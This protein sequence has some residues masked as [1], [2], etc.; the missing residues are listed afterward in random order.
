M[1]AFFRQFQ[2]GDVFP[3]TRDFTR[4]TFRI[5]VPIIVS[6]FFAALLHVIDNY[7]IGQLGVLELAAVTQ[8]NRITFLFQLVIFGLSGGT[9]AYVSQY[10]GK[11]DMKGIHSVMGLA[12][13]LSTLS[14]L[15]FILPCVLMP[16]QL[17]SLLLKDQ[18]SVNAAAEYLSIIVLGY[19][20]A[21]ITQCYGTVQKSTEQ[22]RLS[23]FASITALAMN[24]FLNYCLIFGN[25][26]LPRLGIRGGAIATVIAQFTELLI[27]VIGGYIYRFATAAKLSELI[28]RSFAFA[29]K[30]LAIA[31]PVIA[32]EGLWALGVVVCSAVYGRMGTEAV[33]SLSIFNTVQ[34]VAMVGMRGITV[35]AAT[36]IGKRIG[37][38][39]ED[40]AQHTA[41]RM[42]YA[43]IPA[44]IFTG[45]VLIFVCNPLTYHFNVSFQVAADARAMIWISAATAWINQMA[46][47]LIVGVM[48]AGGD[49]KMSLYVDA[50][51]IWIIGVPLVALGG[52]VL[53]LP[54]PLVY[55][56][57]NGEG[58]IKTWLGLR[59]FRSRKWIHNIVK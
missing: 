10:W 7:M 58:I 38:G 20:A 40:G 47:L 34:Q 24:T 3:W 1:S 2:N 59:R 57:S 54:V 35:A 8:A 21:A 44:G 49:V 14:A 29:K 37:A 12:L 15:C 11:R 18:A 43:A 52:L 53:G 16:G 4:E 42:I 22:A 23:M 17:M 48:R 41:K 56:V 50:G 32:N 51:S 5:A 28:P 25:L 36:L 6:S 19:L 46:G 26:G 9:A 33:A 31:M 27:V 30:Y 13:T 39:D 55:L 45:L